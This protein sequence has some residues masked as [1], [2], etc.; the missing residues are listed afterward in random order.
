MLNPK[1]LFVYPAAIYA[2]IFLFISVLVGA[3]INTHA[4][5]VTVATLII[6]IIGL[7]IASR[8]AKV[9]SAKNAVILG[10]VWVAVMV[11]LDLVLTA[12]FTGYGYF[13]AWTTYLSYAITFVIPVIF[14]R[15]K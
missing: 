1:K 13:A 12:P 7:Y 15:E 8:A 6:S 4:S 10:L 9:D 2:V 3:K 14:S 11:V 5:W